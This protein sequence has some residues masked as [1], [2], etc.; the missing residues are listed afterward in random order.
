[1]RKGF[2]AYGLTTLPTT[3]SDEVKLT[4][5][6]K[7][8]DH[9]YGVRNNQAAVSDLRHLLNQVERANNY[10]QVGL[11]YVSD[12]QKWNLGLKRTT[13]YRTTLGD[14]KHNKMTALNLYA[15]YKISDGCN[16]Y[17][18]SDH[19]SFSRNDQTMKPKVYA[20]GVKVTF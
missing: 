9:L 16:V 7:L 12:C 4:Y 13:S 19:R 15:A 18:E 20:A 2:L 8:Y 11:G 17:L 5:M 10:W 6:Q 14:S 3:A 1:M